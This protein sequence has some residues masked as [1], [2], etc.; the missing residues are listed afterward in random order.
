MVDD[1][2]ENFPCKWDSENYG[3]LKGKDIECEECQDYEEKR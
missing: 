3:C 1:T 2:P